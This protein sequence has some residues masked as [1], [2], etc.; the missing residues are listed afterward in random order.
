MAI[1]RKML[2]VLGCRSGSWK[3]RIQG[4]TVMVVQSTV[5]SLICCP[6]SRDCTRKVNSIKVGTGSNCLGAYMGGG[7]AQNMPWGLDVGTA[8]M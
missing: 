5:R 6:T 8:Q 2:V 4:V 7:W 3:N 1:E